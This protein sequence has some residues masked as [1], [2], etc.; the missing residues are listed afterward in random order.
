MAENIQDEE[1]SDKAGSSGGKKKLIILIAIGA[2]LITISVGGTLY[3]LGFF[4]AEEAS[5]E[6]VVPGEITEMKEPAIYYPLKPPF[7]VNYQSRGRQRFLQVSVTVMAREQDAIDAIQMHMPLIKNRLV[8]LFS[9]EVYEELHT[10]EGR[11]LLR[12]K[13]LMAIQTILQQEIGKPGIEQVLFE[14]FVMQ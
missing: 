9:G 6:D 2:L 13:T 5:G 14:N 7:I 12:Q 10:D 4:N 1:S 3:F 8:M 11:E